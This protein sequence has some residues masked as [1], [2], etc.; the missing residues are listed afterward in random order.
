[1]EQLGS[2]EG[3]KK[4][5]SRVQ[6]L[7]SRAGKGRAAGCNMIRRGVAGSSRMQHDKEEGEKLVVRAGREQQGTKIPFF[8]LF[9]MRGQGRAAE[10]A[11]VQG[12]VGK[13]GAAEFLGWGSSRA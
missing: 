9:E 10:G 12:G 3:C 6:L 2:G 7:G 11:A 4:G 8:L 1:M 13:R 5:G